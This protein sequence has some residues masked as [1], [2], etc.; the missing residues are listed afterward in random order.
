MTRKRRT[1]LTVAGA[2]V[3]AAIIL[4]AVQLNNKYGLLEL[5]AQFRSFRV[6]VDNQ[7]DFDLKL[8]EAGVVTSGSI[9]EGRA[10]GSRDELGTTVPKGRALTVRP[11]LSISGEGGIYLRYTDPREPNAPKTIGVCSYTESISGYSKV[12]ITNDKVTVEEKCS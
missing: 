12:I 2:A 10:S 3:I 8:L 6:T 1:I 9:R 11:S 5:V 4:L 7:S